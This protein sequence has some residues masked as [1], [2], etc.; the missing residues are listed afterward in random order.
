MIKIFVGNIKKELPLRPLKEG[1]VERE[2]E[3]ERRLKMMRG[4]KKDNFFSKK[5]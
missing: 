1:V 3:R 4:K 5:F 2:R